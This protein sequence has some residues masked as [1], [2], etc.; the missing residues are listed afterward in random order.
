MKLILFHLK[1]IFQGIVFASFFSIC[2]TILLAQKLKITETQK[3][4]PEGFNWGYLVLG[5]LLI[6]LAGV[7]F[8]W[9]SR[10]KKTVPPDKVQLSSQ[11]KFFLNK[12]LKNSYSKITENGSKP[13]KI[14]GDNSESL[15]IFAITQ[16]ELSG[17][18]LSLLQSEDEILLDA[19]EQA[20]EEAEEDEEMRHLALKILGA[21][22]NQ[23]SVEAISQIALYDLSAALRSKA[24]SILAEFDHESVFETILL[25]CADPS[26][27][28]RAAAARG[29]FRLSFD[30]TEAWLRV[31]ESKDAG[32]VRQAARAVIA[33][34]FVERSI[35]RL[36]HPD[37]QQA[38]EAFAMIT[39]LIKA[40]ETEEIFAT[41]RQSESTNIVKA[42]LHVIKIT[43]HAPALKKLYSMRER[44]KFSI[45]ARLEI[46]EFLESNWSQK[47]LSKEK[48]TL[49][50]S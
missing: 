45:N 6:S 33:G 31:A 24:V 14:A 11:K 42:I 8:W 15:P 35:E 30:R 36:V 41:L 43:R 12:P 38:T 1:T 13:D 27:E 25:A 2:S 39:L 46:E 21:F 9:L 23:N 20:S 22:K 49:T 18:V 10:R 47:I 34:D 19:I 7:I 48:L 44:S 28:V 37:R 40:E 5:I 17:P 26:R 29:L 50:Q 3:P 16:I 4:E 32:R